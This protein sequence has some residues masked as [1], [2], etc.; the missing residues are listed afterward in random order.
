M[1]K[2]W[3]FGIETRVSACCEWK[4]VQKSAHFVNF[5]ALSQLSNCARPFFLWTQK[6]AVAKRLATDGR[7]PAPDFHSLIPLHSS[8]QALFETHH[9]LVSKA[10]LGA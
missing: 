6:T 10:L 4:H 3:L 8:P 9:R 5:K 7:L 2:T 1:R